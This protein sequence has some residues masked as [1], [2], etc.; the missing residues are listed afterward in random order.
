MR[1]LEKYRNRDLILKL[2]DKI[3]KMSK[4]KY[5]FMEVCGTHTHSFSRWGLRSLLRDVVELVPGPGCPVCVTSQG[6]IDVVGQLVE[7]GV[8]V[9]TFGDLMR[10]PG[11]TGS[12][13]EMRASGAKV[14]VAYSP[15]DAVEYARAHPQ[16]KVVMVGIGFETTAPAFASVIIKNPLGNFY[17]LSFLKLIPPALSA[18]LES[19]DIRLDGFL[20]PGHVST[21]IGLRP[22][23]FIPERYG[24]PAVVAGFEPVDM[25]LGILKLI[26]L[27]ESPAVFNA[28]PRVVREEGNTEAQKLMEEVFEP[29]DVEW[30]GL[31]VIERSGLVLRKKYD[32]MDAMKAFNLKIEEK[33]LNPLCRCGDILCGKALPPDCPLFGS[34]CT[35]DTPLGPCMVSSEGACSAWYIYEEL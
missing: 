22:Y 28:Y 35:P 18:L 4:R 31:G 17:F 30:R 3:K 11:S 26:E 15:V 7:K 34:S 9:F 32:R 20:C 8:V 25:L 16:E 21:I 13:E 23:R 33:I 12:L 10:V 2:V 6:Q 27:Q 19:G 14:H 1:V 5:R 24:L 29:V